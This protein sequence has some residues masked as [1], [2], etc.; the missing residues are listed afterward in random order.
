VIDIR[1]KPQFQTEKLVTH[2]QP[3]PLPPRNKPLEERLSIPQK[4]AKI[5]PNH[6]FKD[7]NKAGKAATK[8][9]ISEDQVAEDNIQSTGNQYPCPEAECSKTYSYKSALQRHQKIFHMKE[10]PFNCKIDNCTKEFALQ[11]HLKRHIKQVHSD[12]KPYQ[13]HYC[14]KFFKDPYNLKVHERIHTGEKP[15]LCNFPGCGKSFNQKGAL[16][17]H[18][19]IHEKNKKA[20]LDAKLYACE[21]DECTYETDEKQ[22]IKTHKSTCDYKLNFSSNNPYFLENC[23]VSTCATQCCTEDGTMNLL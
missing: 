4:M 19:R 2:E 13:C 23:G 15:F 6:I 10:K 5:A 9:V 14:D 21:E 3:P 1:K 12:E 11:H 8:N 17:M 18:M 20:K 16:N 22:K 7:V